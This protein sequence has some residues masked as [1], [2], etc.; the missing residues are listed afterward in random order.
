MVRDYIHQG[1]SRRVIQIGLAGLWVVL[2]LMGLGIIF[3]FR[4]TIS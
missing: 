3:Y 4:G 1:L 2:M